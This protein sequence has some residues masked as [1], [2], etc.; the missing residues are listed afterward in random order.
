M[1]RV[2]D[3]RSD[4][5]LLLEVSETSQFLSALP[6]ALRPAWAL[7]YT[8]LLEPKS[9]RLLCAEWPTYKKPKD[10]GPPWALPPKV[11]TAHLPRPGEI[12]PYDDEGNVLEEKLGSERE[13]GL[14]REAHWVPE[15][16]HAPG[17]QDGI[18]TDFI[19]V[20][21]HKSM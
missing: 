17:I 7:R 9:G 4:L 21:K 19:G 3:Q 1:F 2:L 11:Y 10:G 16:T 20:W 15:R 5:P 12:I 18:N 13:D 14:E 8:Q 6:P